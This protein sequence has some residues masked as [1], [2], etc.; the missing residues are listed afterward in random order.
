MSVYFIQDT[1]GFV[2]IGYAR[3]VHARLKALQTA[4]AEHLNLVRV[5]DG[6]KKTESWLHRRFAHLRVRHR[7]EWFSFA[8]EMLTVIA[9]DEIPLPARQVVRFRSTAAFL[10]SVD[11]CGILTDEMRRTYGLARSPE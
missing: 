4:V 7:G 10:K 6:G 5:I 2:K 9:P 3:D 11:K 8:P 1:S